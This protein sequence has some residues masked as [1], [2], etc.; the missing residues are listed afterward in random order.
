MLITQQLNVFTKAAAEHRIVKSCA[1]SELDSV[2]SSFVFE[3]VGRVRRRV[4]R[5]LCTA[6][7]SSIFVSRAPESEKAVSRENE[8]AR[9]HVVTPPT[10]WKR[11]GRRTVVLVVDKSLLSFVVNASGTSLFIVLPE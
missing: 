9:R 2:Y 3:F 4:N 11:D 7:A 5:S 10:Q 6:A 8:R 1:V